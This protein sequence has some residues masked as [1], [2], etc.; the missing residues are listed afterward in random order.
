MGNLFGKDKKT[1]SEV[2]IDELK[3][4]LANLEKLDKNNDGVVSKD[5]LDDWMKEQ[6]KDIDNFK[7]KIEEKAEAKYQKVLLDNERELSDRKIEIKELA[8][9]IK[10]LKKINKSLEHKI[11]NDDVVLNNT[12]TDGDGEGVNSDSFVKIDQQKLSELSKKRINQF[13]E[14]LLDDENIN[15]AYF[16]DAIERQIYRNVFT[17]L[18]N[19]LDSLFDTTSVKFL[20]HKL[21][22]DMMP[23]EE[24]ES[25][26]SPNSDDIDENDQL[27][28]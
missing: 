3:N 21:V 19:L 25:S 9:E 17:I 20:G 24:G 4:R 26:D 5:E 8:K 12:S 1:K 27:K 28:T 10:S 14:T 13:V 16:P 11:K 2:D 18:V 6:K 23:L 22:F 7:K 15:I